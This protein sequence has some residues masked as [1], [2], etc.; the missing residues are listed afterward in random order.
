MVVRQFGRS[1]SFSVRS[2]PS[3]RSASR[4]GRRPRCSRCCTGLPQGDNSRWPGP[5]TGHSLMPGGNSASC[6]RCEGSNDAGQEATGKLV[7][8]GGS[9]LP[10]APP[11]ERYGSRAAVHRAPQRASVCAAE[12]SM[13]ARESTW[14]SCRRARSQRRGG[15][16]LPPRSQLVCGSK[17]ACMLES[18]ASSIRMTRRGKRTGGCMNS[19]G[20]GWRAG[21]PDLSWRS[22]CVP[23]NDR[24]GGG[25]RLR[26]DLCLAAEA[27]GAGVPGSQPFRASL[28]G[29]QA[30][31]AI[32]GVADE[33]WA[34]VIPAGAG[35]VAAPPV[36]PVPGGPVPAG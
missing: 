24:P 1:T 17:A 21:W 29:P 3:A 35:L 23:G 18:P 9:P 16:T 33:P 31:R 6:R 27:S 5:V 36:R 20:G 15:G 19:G 28:A 25:R 13:R 30:R 34:L 26:D 2:T 4:R 11:A 10:R 8:A 32:F 22:P 12:C 14:W 7:R